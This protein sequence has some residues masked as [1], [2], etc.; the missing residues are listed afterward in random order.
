MAK[1][2]PEKKEPKAKKQPAGPP[3]DELTEDQLDKVAGGFPISQ[4]V[5]LGA[6]GGAGSTGKPKLGGVAGEAQ[7]HKH[8]EGLGVSS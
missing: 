6:L 5:V 3:K 2:K 7:D 8:D 1:K 4:G